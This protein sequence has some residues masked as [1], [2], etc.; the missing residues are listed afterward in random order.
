MTAQEFDPLKHRRGAHGKFVDMLRSLKPGSAVQLP[1]GIHVK[2]VNAKHGQGRRRKYQVIHAN[3][4]KVGGDHLE[5]GTAA[6]VAL[7]QSAQHVHPD[8]VGGARRYENFNHAMGEGQQAAEAAG[9]AAASGQ[10]NIAQLRAAYPADTRAAIAK[11]TAEQRRGILPQMTAE[12]LLRHLRAEQ[13]QQKRI[14]NRPAPAKPSQADSQGFHIKEEMLGGFGHY[15]EGYH[16]EKRFV[17]Y[18][19]DQPGGAV[20]TSQSAA[21]ANMKARKER[22]AVRQEQQ[23]KRAAAQPAGGK[24]DVAGPKDKPKASDLTPGV[25]KLTHS[26][27]GEMIY[28][29]RNATNHHVARKVADG[30]G[31]KKHIIRLK[32][33]TLGHGGG[34]GGQKETAAPA[35]AKPSGSKPSNGA[36][37]GDKAVVIDKQYQDLIAAA[38]N[39]DAKNKLYKEYREFI[40]TGKVGPSIGKA[41]AAQDVGG[42]PSDAPKVVSANKEGSRYKQGDV[43]RVYGKYD[44]VHQGFDAQG[45]HVVKFKM[46]K[47][48]STRKF[49]DGGA[50]KFLSMK[51]QAK[52]A[53]DMKPS[54]QRAAAERAVAAVN[55]E[56][57]PRRD[58]QA[59]ADAAHR[60]DVALPGVAKGNKVSRNEAIAAAQKLKPGGKLELNN[61]YVIERSKDGK[62]FAASSQTG[63]V[64]GVDLEHAVNHAH[65]NGGLDGDKMKRYGIKA[66]TPEYIKRFIVNNKPVDL[67]VPGAK[68]V[69]VDNQQH[70]GPGNSDPDYGIF[71]YVVMDD[72]TVVHEEVKNRW[73]VENDVRQLV[74]EHRG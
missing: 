13:A 65:L 56:K 64:A 4:K 55:K 40:R 70:A 63:G 67:N 24:R 29:G 6:Q 2:A 30:E 14:A 39:L 20:F 69:F 10:K 42:V 18:G 47:G 38:P 60:G 25:T 66:D 58:A 21:E 7:N 52:P 15:Q 54:E 71:V 27:H 28:M 45:N 41:N 62:T 5:A 72:G 48:D 61:G 32:E 11:V 51:R 9:G 74:K 43:V 36:S 3:G 12:G 1:D 50:K 53:K 44:G 73:N 17:V 16:K 33:I 19:P 34:G 31:G 49:S 26:Q 8:A 37:K 35:A 22:H 59:A 23:A 68:A 46:A 57:Q